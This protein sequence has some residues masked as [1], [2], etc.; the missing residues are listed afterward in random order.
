M[1]NY[2]QF[3]EFIRVHLVSVVLAFPFL[4]LSPVNAQPPRPVIKFA[5]PAGGQR[6][7]SVEVIVSGTELQGA[8]DV[9]ITGGGVTAKVVKV[10]NPNTVRTTVAI[11]PDA[12][13]GE[14]DLRVITPARGVSNRF[15]FVV[16]ELP[17]I[18]E[19]EPNSLK[20]QAQTLE[21][22]PVLI[23]G[24]VLPAD[25]DF[26][27]F[28]AKAGQTLVCEV[29]ARKLLP[30]IADAVPGWL[31]AHLTLYD[32]EGK[33]LA[34]AG[35]SRFDPDPVLI[36]DVPKDGDYFIEI[37]DSFYRG[38]EDFIYKLSIGN[39]PYITRV[40]PLGGKRNSDVLVELQGANLP[41][42]SLKVTLPGDSAPL[43]FVSSSHNGLN[44]NALPF[45]VSD[46]R[47]TRETAPNV[48]FDK[49]TLVEVPV[50]IN[51]R[52][53]RSRD[54]QYFRF[55]AKGGQRFVLEVQARRL[56]SPLDSII[57]L[58]NSEGA[59]LAEQDDTDMGDPLLTHH[60][61]SR[62]DYT[63]PVDGDYVVRIQDVQG[64]GGEAYAYRL[65]IAPPRPDFALRIVPENPRLGAADCAFVTV[66]ALRKD[67]FNGDIDLAVRNLPKGFLA[68][69]AVI[70]AGQGETRLTVTAPPNAPVALFSPN[71][72]G[73]ATLD[74]EAVTRE[75]SGA[76]DV[77]QA[78]SLRH[79]VPTREFLV[80]VI[81]S[82]DFTLSTNLLSTEV[83][84]VRRESQ[85]L[86]VVKTLRKGIEA[87]VTRAE[88]AKNAIE[89]ASA[90]L[91]AESAKAT[92]G[93]GAA[94]KTAQ[95]AEGQA[96]GARTAASQAA[97]ALANA[98]KAAAAAR[99][100]ATAAKKT[101][102]DLL[103]EQK[104][105]AG[106]ALTS[107][108]NQV[109]VATKAHEAAEK[110]ARDAETAAATAQAAADKARQTQL[111]AENAAGETRALANE[112][113]GKSNKLAADQ[114]AAAA[115][116]EQANKN[117]DAVRT[118][119]KQEIRL[120]A[121]VLPPGITFQP[122]NITADKSEATVTFTITPQAPL[123]L[124]QNCIITGTMGSGDNAVVHVAP[125]IP[126]TI[127]ESVKVLA[128]VA[129]SK[130]QQANDAKKKL[131]DVVQ[132][133]QK[134]A[135]ARLAAAAQAVNDATIAKA[136]T[137]KALAQANKAAAKAQTDHEA[138]EK[139]AKEAEATAQAI[140]RDASKSA[141]EKKKAAEAAAAQHKAADAGRTTLTEAQKKQQQ[142]QT[143]TDTAA[144]KLAEAEAQKKA[145]EQAL[146][147]VKNQLAPA[148]QAYQ[149]AEEA[150]KEAEMVAAKAKSS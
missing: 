85:V 122:A 108:N 130:R 81:E 91:K 76:E 73:T 21:S 117:L 13:L 1:R 69:K 125:A 65:D 39:L 111:A 15:R 83:R 53:Q 24:Q 52:I 82:A 106:Q 93:H 141:E 42:K 26:F 50:T 97:I 74:K 102:D 149:Q 49:A 134:P 45:A 127:L 2:T 27:R 72:V 112:A 64:G 87:A 124:R 114:K 43:R 116:L 4:G 38:R 88:A 37:R 90:R 20:S 113:K 138:A 137:D 78:F 104:K 139:S 8:T 3:Y 40:F 75:A 133:L 60:A 12:E 131:D 56:G 11:A 109:A 58:F 67:G 118:K 120:T 144:K 126:I 101:L 47:E 95:A 59:Q 57:T 48:S 63:F 123:G 25:K 22:L 96:A 41:T 92:A 18:T 17:E 31:E 46:H 99:Q 103:Q 77:M 135:E 51:G 6:G 98:R 70:A 100:L 107:V 132:K 61:D 129:A 19:K 55:T 33:E 140:S 14:R 119:A 136:A 16:G 9:R 7:K 68:S 62:L 23:N 145:A 94:E 147:G 150:A 34:S 110:A 128:A 143:P 105:A 35:R 5:F 32:A 84:D 44:S 148:S 79:D 54:A 80:A 142:A 71:I 146:A 30:Y 10:E 89:A 121:D 66:K 86:V 36:Y 115:P 28:A 29:Q